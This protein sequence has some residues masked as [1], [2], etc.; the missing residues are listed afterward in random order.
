M[1][2]CTIYSHH[3]AFDK[4]VALVKKHLPKAKVEIEDAGIQKSLVATLKGGLLS[5]SKSLKINY[6]E[7]ENPS[8]TLE[9]PECGLT[10]NLVGMVNFIQSIPAEDTELR[11]KFLYKVMSANSELPFMAEP[12]IGKT[13]EPLLREITETLDAFIFTPPSKFFNQSAEQHFVDKNFDL[14]LD[15]NGRSIARDIEVKVDAKYYNQEEP[16]DYTEEQLVRKAKSEAYLADHAIKVNPNLPCT[17]SSEEVMLR[18]DKEIVD[19]AY[20]LMITAVKGEG[21]EQAHLEKAVEAKNIDSLSPREQHIYQAESL[22]DQER[23]YSVWRYESLNTLLWAM[24][25]VDELS[26]PKEVCDAKEVVRILFQPARAEFEQRVQLRSKVDILD[27]LDKVYRMNWACVDARMK[28]ETPS[29]NMNPSI[30]YERHYALNWLTNYQ[31]QAWDEVQTN[32]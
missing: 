7:R 30:V 31:S 23:A 6:R 10:Q 4:V 27:E 29:G 2:H 12:E 14:L 24:G 17:P 28:G 22:T 11:G 15:T 18:T 26:F 19:R 13:F 3:L 21:I 32:T 1:E 25:I 20:A 5:K 9:Q 16:K 8:Y